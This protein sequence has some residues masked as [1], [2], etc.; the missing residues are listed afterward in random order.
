MFLVLE[1]ELLEDME[2]FFA[3]FLAQKLAKKPLTVVGDGEQ[4]RDFTFVDD[5]INAFI[6][7]LD[8]SIKK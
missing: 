1:Q 4:T 5:V 3:E 7:M 8:K 6:E 2:R